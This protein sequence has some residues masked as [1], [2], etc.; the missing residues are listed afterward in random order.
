M[1]DYLVKKVTPQN[2]T[3]YISYSDKIYRP[4]QIAWQFNNRN[5]LATKNVELAISSYVQFF[6]QLSTE[7]EKFDSE[8]ELYGLIEE[9]NE[10]Y[11]IAKC[12]VNEENGVIEK[13]KFDIA[14][15]KNAL[16]LIEGEAFTLQIKT[17]IGERRFIFQNSEKRIVPSLKEYNLFNDLSNTAFFKPDSD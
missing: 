2:E 16:T 7:D 6:K 1:E 15:L 13:R 10:N 8:I 5:Q 17:R 14:P 12:V 3:S 4:L 9:V 11:I